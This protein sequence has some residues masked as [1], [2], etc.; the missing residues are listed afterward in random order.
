MLNIVLFVQIAVAFVLQ[1]LHLDPY[2]L[3][4]SSSAGVGAASG[5][6]DPEIAF[7]RR[8]GTTRT[9]NRFLTLAR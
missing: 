2:S 7:L 3:P 6:D 8:H 5:E 9:M 4:T 1:A